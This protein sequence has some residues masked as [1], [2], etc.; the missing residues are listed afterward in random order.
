MREQRHTDLVSQAEFARQIGT[1]RQYVNR[2]VRERK[3]PTIGRKIPLR[4]ALRAYTAGKDPRQE[5]GAELR[6]HGQHDA[7]EGSVELSQRI[8][9]AQLR[10]RTAKTK[11][12]ELE[13][14]ER[15][16]RLVS[17]D[18]VRAD[19]RRTAALVRT[20]LLAMGDRLAQQLACDCRRAVE[21]KVLIE[22]EVSDA[23]SGLRESSHVAND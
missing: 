19:A 7:P 22:R 15:A 5:V 3:I 23:I 14:E 8:K 18:E 1:S 2:L 16:G 20:R 13:L 9:M 4:R 6:G 21:V 11:L 12:A 17:V 10:H